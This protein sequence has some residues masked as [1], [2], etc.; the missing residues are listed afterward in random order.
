MTSL[1]WL[2]KKRHFNI[3]F[4]EQEK[5]GDVGSFGRPHVILRGNQ[6][7]AVFLWVLVHGLASIFFL[8]DKV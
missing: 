7:H 4:I 8:S 5:T 3:L 6:A 2:E 1:W